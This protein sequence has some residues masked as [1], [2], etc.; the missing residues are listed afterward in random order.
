M[1]IYIMSFIFFVESNACIRELFSEDIMMKNPLYKIII[2]RRN[3]RD[4][5][6]TIQQSVL[7]ARQNCGRQP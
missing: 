4:E 7:R 5:K 3:S 6:H 2:T 1:E